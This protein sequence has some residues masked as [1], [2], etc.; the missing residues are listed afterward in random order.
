MRRPASAEEPRERA[1]TVD[2]LAGVVDVLREELRDTRRTVEALRD[3]VAQLEAA[4]EGV[5]KPATRASL[6]PRQEAERRRILEALE[7]TDGNRLAAAKAIG[8]PRRTF[9][10]RLAA[11]GI[12]G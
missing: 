2:Y 1:M 4:R 9:Y 3:R 7:A 10:R 12:Q 11:Y 6:P 8:M 5:E